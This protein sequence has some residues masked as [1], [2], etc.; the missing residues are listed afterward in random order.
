MQ[1]E[2]ECLPFSAAT[3]DLV[4]SEN[5]LMWV[6]DLDRAVREVTR[7][8]EPGGALVALEPDFGGMMEHPP[9]IA[10]Q[11]LWLTGLSAAGADPLV[12][13]KIPGACER[14]GL[15]VWAELQGLPQP[16][17]GAGARL[18]L[19]LPLTASQRQRVQTTARALDARS[20]LWD[21]FVHVPYVLVVADKPRTAALSRGSAR[22]G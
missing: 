9:E 11:D 21:P 17:D 10:L 1:A 15:H 2:A 22:S 4:V 19:G 5:V 16:A 6:S 12:G 20:G 3:F 13:R 8:L 18:L 7:C 14:A